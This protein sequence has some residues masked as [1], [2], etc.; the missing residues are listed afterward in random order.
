M[1]H[2]IPNTYVQTL[3]LLGSYNRAA[4]KDIRGDIK[5]I[6]ILN[7]GKIKPDRC[8]A[9]AY[10]RPWGE[11]LLSEPVGSVV[12]VGAVDASVELPPLPEIV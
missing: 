5:Q 2:K 4:A 8:R 3:Y 9:R 1:R 6:I 11:I 10:L 7:M 12:P